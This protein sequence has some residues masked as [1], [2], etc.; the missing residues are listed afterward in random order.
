[1]NLS[2]WEK[3]SF[4][5]YDYVIIGSGIVGLSTAVSIKELSPHASVLI[6]EKGIFPSGAST[7]NAGFACFGSLTELLDDLEK[8]PEKEVL[9]LVKRRWEGLH[10]L[11]SRLG[12]ESIDFRSYGGY[13]LFSE[14]ND[15]RLND[16]DKI[17]RMLKQ[18]FDKPV[19]KL[20]DEKIG[21]FGFDRKNVKHL[22][23]N[24]FEGQIDTGKMMK[25]LLS[26]AKKR[27]V[28]I[29]TGADVRQVRKE[30]KGIR[31]HLNGSN[32]VTFRAAKLGIC[33]N[34]F[35]KNL[36]PELELFPGRGQVLVTKPLKD[37]KFRGVFHLDRGYFYF[38]NYGE[39]V[40]LGGG[41]NLFER[42]ETTTEFD[43]SPEIKAVL[44]DKLKSVIIPG[45]DFEIDTMWSG[46]MAFGATKKPVLEEVD[47][48]IFTAV[49]LGGMGVA[50]G[51][52]LGEELAKKM[53]Q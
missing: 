19:F 7:K 40:I 10:K 28:E 24:E 21:A 4:L 36:L 30:E 46:I 42:A 44:V 48:N 47:E 31:I 35:S 39:R 8:M 26:H 15:S 33:T 43:T 20:S 13:E 14:R 1:M 50:L 2:F 17:N 41:R 11:R 45:Q 52:L 38:R 27:G 9:S 16:M 3:Q 49:R 29:I 34:A 53:L 25:S 6:L 12:D 22:V 23:E 18:V 37:L 51:S 32:E 5:E